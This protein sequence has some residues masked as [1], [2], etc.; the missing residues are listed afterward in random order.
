[1]PGDRILAGRGLDHPAEAGLGRRR[2]RHA[3]QGTDI[4]QPELLEGRQ[5]E[6]DL[7]ADVAQRVAALVAVSARIRQLAD[8]DAVE[9]DED[10]AV[11]V[12]HVPGVPWR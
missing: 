8:A 12:T 3:A 1:M 7:P 9:Y 10:D 5:V 2:R 11:D 6:V 4:A